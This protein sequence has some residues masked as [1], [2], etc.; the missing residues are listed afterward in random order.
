[1]INEDYKSDYDDA[2][3]SYLDA[4]SRVDSWLDDAQTPRED[5]A[6]NIINE[7]NKMLDLEDSARER[8]V[9]VRNQYLQ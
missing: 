9:S 6:I 7:T 8:W 2:L 5:N 3:Q 4:R 1:M